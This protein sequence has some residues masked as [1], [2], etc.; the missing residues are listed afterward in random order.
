MLKIG[1]LVVYGSE[2]VCEIVDI[3]SQSF[4]RI[5]T[6]REYYVLNPKVNSGAKIYVPLDNE[7]LCKRIKPL[8]T[9]N[10]LTSLIADKSLNLEW[11]NDNKQRSKYY[12]D[13]FS[14]YERKSIFATARMIYEIKS[15]KN[16]EI[17][18]LYSIDED[19]LKKIT[20]M[21]Y[22]EISY[23]VDISEEQVLPLICGEITVVE[24]K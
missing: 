8:L 11:I 9:Y 15:G 5:S 22:S 23:I 21:I 16:A 2:G 19:A 24:R 17:S 1:M 14:T 12:K 6:K 7:L 4:S 10:E 3:Q 18:R 20:Q 13:L